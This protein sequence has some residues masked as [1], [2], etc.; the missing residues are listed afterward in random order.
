[1]QRACVLA[2]ALTVSEMSVAGGFSLIEHGASGLGNAYAGAA[3]VSLDASTIWFNPAGMT[4][5]KEKQFIAAGHIIDVDSEFTDQGTTLNSAFGGD[6]V[7]PN[8]GTP[9]ALGPV[10]AGGTAFLP[11]LY[12][13]HP[14]KKG[15]T[16]GIGL[17]I[18]YGNSTDYDPTWV[19]RYQAVESSVTAIDINPSISYRVNDVLNIGGGIS[20]QYLTANIGNAVDSGGTCFGLASAGQLA[21]AD[22]LGAGLTGPGIAAT[23]GFAD[24]EGDST[25]FTFNFGLLYKPRAGTNLGFAFRSGVEHELEGTAD[26]TNNPAFETLLGSNGIP[27]FLDGDV[28]AEADLPP[29]A[30]FSVAHKAT[31]RL[32]LLADATFTG[33]SSFDELR[34]VFDNPAQPDT[35]NTIAYEDVWRVSAG[36]NYEYSDQWT[37]RGGVAF[38]EDPTPSPVLRTSR[39]PGNDRTWVSFGVG[40]KVNKR[41]GVDVSFAHLMLDDT[42]IANVG[43]SAGGTTT[44]GIFDSFVNILSAQVVVQFD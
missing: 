37:F 32:Q 24:V 15:V 25:A 1:M 41:V 29:T 39:I 20:V 19:G 7:D 30:M 2:F 6:F 22:C 23:D 26:F 10:D 27:L 5:L 14:L 43:E 35:F 8:F 44:R 17:G 36:V 34:V 21:L 12:Y 28:T 16:L 18:P 40:Y 3:A 11:N 9:D 38:D 42:P 33:W 4:E 13:V 31:D